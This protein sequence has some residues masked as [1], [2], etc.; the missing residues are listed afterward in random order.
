MPPNRPRSTGKRSRTRAAPT[1][2]P[3]SPAGHI[4]HWPAR[5]LSEAEEELEREE[6]E[7]YGRYGAGIARELLEA[8]PLVEIQTGWGHLESARRVARLEAAPPP[9]VETLLARVQFPATRQELVDSAREADL[10]DEALDW[11][12]ALPDRRFLRPEVVRP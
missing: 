6:E 8:A 10:S 4:R 11:L 9:G 1:V 3:R 5:P 7:L 2:P 12:A